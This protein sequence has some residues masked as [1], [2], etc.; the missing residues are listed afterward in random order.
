M[1]VTDPIQACDD[2]KVAQAVKA[3]NQKLAALDAERTPVDP[4]KRLGQLETQQR[5]LKNFVA[6]A[7]R[8]LNSWESQLSE[9]RKQMKA[10]K[11]AYELVKPHRH[12]EAAAQ[13]NRLAGEIADLQRDLA[14]VKDRR[15]GAI[16]SHGDAIKK[17]QAFVERH[18]AEV[19]ELLKLEQALRAAKNA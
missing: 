15:D 2:L 5:D 14:K 4:F 11:T 8:W 17:L 7:D 1:S 3:H 18:G 6:D 19:A 16:K 13:A 12:P 9:I 10:K